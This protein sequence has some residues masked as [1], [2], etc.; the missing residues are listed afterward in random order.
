MNVANGGRSSR[1]LI[2]LENSEGS[3]SSS[4]SESETDTAVTGS[5]IR[6]IKK[7]WKQKYK[8]SYS[9]QYPCF[10]AS[11][12]SKYHA[13]C[14][15]CQIDIVISHGGLNDISRHC[16]RKGHKD[17]A[18]LSE[19]SHFFRTDNTTN[20]GLSVIKSEVLFVHF[21]VEHNLSFSTADHAA[22]LFK[23][24]FSSKSVVDDFKCG[25]TKATAIMKVMASEVKS[26]IVKNLNGPFVIATDGSTLNNEKFYPIVVR[27]LD[28]QGEIQ[29]DLLANPVF[30][31]SHTG[32]S[33]FGIL[34][35]EL[36][37]HNID[38]KKC[39]ALVCDNTYTMVG[40]YRGVIKYVRDQ[41]KDVFLAGCVC[42]LLH[43]AS[44]KGTKAFQAEFNFDIVLRQLN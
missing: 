5:R 18:K 9:A 21:L 33:I 22:K 17:K 14:T 29:S 37:K 6:M 27:Y 36:S 1:D 40:K 20:P 24:M 23:K 32:E 26:D 11:K 31:D 15:I 2:N 41:H 19:I 43:L 38:W 8:R 34:Q 30:N 25:R 13:R 44:K 16:E 42:H 10:I 12:L 4:E 39:T 35:R 3:P 28:S 7:Y